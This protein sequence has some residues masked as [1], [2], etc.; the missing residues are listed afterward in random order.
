MVWKGQNSIGIY[1]H[2]LSTYNRSRRVTDTRH[3]A[4]DT[5]PDFESSTR[6][7]GPISSQQTR[8]TAHTCPQCHS[9]ATLPPQHTAA[10][11]TDMHRQPEHGSRHNCAH[12]QPHTCTTLQHL[13]A[14]PC[15]P[16]MLPSAPPCIPCRHP[17]GQS[18]HGRRIPHAVGR[19]HVVVAHQTTE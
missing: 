11:K 13:Q 14:G 9:W 6:T 3:S 15:C 8:S 2:K 10:C 1:M 17:S 5:I 19:H 4:T 7:R 12:P 18:S 16:I